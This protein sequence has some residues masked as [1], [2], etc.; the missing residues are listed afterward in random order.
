[1]ATEDM[2]SQPGGEAGLMQ[3]A[4][5]RWG[6][7]SSDVA[8]PLKMGV[9]QAMLSQGPPYIMGCTAIGTLRKS[10][11]D[12][13]VL[14]ASVTWKTALQLLSADACFA[15]IIE[16]GNDKIFRLVVDDLCPPALAPDS[17]AGAAPAHSTER[18]GV[19]L[20]TSLGGEAVAA[21]AR[22][23]Q[24]WGPGSS[25]RAAPLKLGVA[26]AILDLGPPYVIRGDHIGLLRSCLVEGGLLDAS[27]TW[28]VALERLSADACFAVVDNNEDGPP[29]VFRLCL[30]SLRLAAGAPAA[31]GA[32]IPAP[33]AVDALALAPAP[34]AAA[35]TTTRQH[36]GLSTVVDAVAASARFQ[37][38][39]GPG[40]L[41]RAAPLKLA[42]AEAMLSKGPPFEVKSGTVGGLRKSL[43]EDEVLP[44]SIT[45]AVAVKLLRTDTCF[46]TIESNNDVAF[47]LCVDSLGSLEDVAAS[48]LAR[49]EEL[50]GPGSSD[51]AAPLKL[52]V[53]KVMLK[54][55]LPL[56]M[57]GSQVGTLRKGLVGRKVLDGSITEAAALEC[58]S[59]D[60]CFAATD[61]LG[62]KYKGQTVFRLRLAALMPE[63]A[64][65]PVEG[66]AA[67]AAPD[68]GPA[69]PAA[70]APAAAAA[71]ATPEPAAGAAE[72]AAPAP[73]AAA[74]AAAP[75]SKR[76]HAETSEQ[77]A[78]PGT[79]G[80]AASLLSHAEELW[81]PGSADPIAPL[82]LAVAKALLMPN[83]PPSFTKADVIESLRT[84]LVRDKVLHA[85][86]TWGVA[87]ELI[88]ADPCFMS[89]GKK[90][91]TLRLNPDNLRLAALDPAAAAAAAS[92]AADASGPAA[93]RRRTAPSAADAADRPTV[94]W[95]SGEPATDAAHIEA[96]SQLQ[97]HARASGAVGMDA[98]WQGAGALTQLCL[99][100]LHMQRTARHADT[101]YLLD[102]VQASPE[103]LT[104][105]MT[106]LG[107]LLKDE[108]VVKVFHGCRQDIA[109]LRRACAIPAVR[110]VL[111][112][113]L[114]QH[115][116]GS[117]HAPGGGPPQP[118]STGRL[119]GLGD[120]LTLNG[121]ET[122]ATR[123]MVHMLM[124]ARPARL[125]LDRP[126]PLYLQE[127]AV[128]SVRLLIP[129]A[130]RQLH[131][132]T[133][134]SA[135]DDSS[136]QLALA[137]CE[138]QMPELRNQGQLAAAATAAEHQRLFGAADGIEL[139]PRTGCTYMMAFDASH[140][141]ALSLLPP[142]DELME[143]G[144]AEAAVAGGAFMGSGGGGGDSGDDCVDSMLQ[145]L[146]QRIHEPLRAYVA[147]LARAEG[148]DVA[149]RQ[150]IEIAIDE[151]RDIGLR[152]RSGRRCSVPGLQV[153]IVE[154]IATLQAVKQR[155]EAEGGLSTQA[156][157]LHP[158][159]YGGVREG[160]ASGRSA[161]ADAALFTSDGRLGL[162]GTLHRISR[163]TVDRHG[164]VYNLTY[165]VGRHVPG[166]AAIFAD[167]LADLCSPAEGL[168]GQRPGIA[169][170]HSL[171]LV[172]PPGV[173]TT[174]LLRDITRMLADVFGKAVN[175]VDTSNEIA[176][177]YVR[178]HS[179][180]GSARRF[181][182]PD[183]TRQDEV[184]MEVVQN[185][186]PQVV[187]V[188]EI[189]TLQEV[190]AIRTISQRGVIAVGTAHGTN[191]SS[192]LNN[193]EL[194]DLVGGIETV[195]LGDVRAFKV[196]AGQKTRQERARLPTFTML[197]EVLAENRWRVH[198][199]VAA[200][201]DMLL[202][203]QSEAGGR[204][205]APNGVSH[206]L[207]CTETRAYD[208]AGGMVVELH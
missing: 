1:M 100:Q 120:I 43:V 181:M 165:R 116:A 206:D 26:V 146:P 25:D 85:A 44:A 73:T 151:G 191:L 60:P 22:V 186:T 155:S 182:V 170:F 12:D 132:G 98:E 64:A 199:N 35:P 95:I 202:A 121:F 46:I 201:V 55:G 205:P 172:G 180:I 75:G 192:L 20:S 190:R 117:S 133:I 40:S 160:D 33:A 122:P 71:A 76:Q 119:L 13:A 104:C 19:A 118:A 70:P 126:L 134:T 169:G 18:Q 72:A 83:G 131:R 14:D 30:D 15:T 124:D 154:A 11:V 49:V 21:R 89:S 148:P 69:A 51:C 97:S 87:V 62:N 163:G 92:A 28:P 66:D 74:A 178:P 45:W 82:K 198:R 189:G 204:E 194:S 57:P 65:P 7:G 17:D 24:L 37:E 84:A 108:R 56:V 140:R 91:R 167:L 59:S 141:P 185:H 123:Q 94:V 156:P 147:E 58:L 129:V 16:H 149:W 27:I 79:A 34:A 90:G 137:Y 54:A 68:A 81:G 105:M 161:G 88:N 114:L 93:K 4:E 115:T 53:A 176:G 47:R 86:V 171:L 99:V 175:V 159:N 77:T 78:P 144:T 52:A 9:V 128:D 63:S 136:C 127:Y 143:G 208:A 177:D 130:K 50:W 32:A 2:Q 196:N 153:P 39:W 111:D 195:T 106:A 109:I 10:L 125:W 101:V 162:P 142:G 184:L 31:A 107:L 139:Q 103:R 8:G 145:M 166:I 193:H 173:G 3:L 168:P 207:P 113:Q 36:V 6:L 188:D 112:V 38:L 41:D 61:G 203:A 197:I 48:L 29:K 42:V 152:F 164:R 158:S 96:L 183:R 110:S 102:L 200:S 157:E 67:A 135:H 187:V 174:T 23:E 138:S 150:L 5:Q 179:C 80:D